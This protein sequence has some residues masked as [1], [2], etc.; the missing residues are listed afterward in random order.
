MTPEEKALIHSLV[1]GRRT[2]PPLSKSEFLE[3]YKEDDGTALAERLITNAVREKDSETLE[4]SL[5][6][7][8]VFGVSDELVDPLSEAV[9]EDWHYSH[10]NIVS[11][12]DRLRTPAAIPAFIYAARHVPDYLD[13][14]D[15]RALAVKAIWGLG[16][17]PAPEAEEALHSLLDSSN[18]V[19][20]R[21]VRGQLERR[22]QTA[23]E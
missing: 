4:L 7:G 10:E 19:V 20:D 3:R 5:I 9:A 14:D 23:T 21:N 6:V 17:L 18:E 1:N 11:M 12:L 2:G 16:N 8:F 15:A 22:S 13:F